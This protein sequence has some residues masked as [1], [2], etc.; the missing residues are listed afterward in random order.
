MDR[1]ELVKSLKKH[2]FN[3]FADEWYYGLVENVFRDMNSVSNDGYV[4]FIK[5]HYT[6]VIKIGRSK[7][8]ISRLNSIKTNNTDKMYLIGYIYTNEY[9]ELEKELHIKFKEK[10]K[11]G[12]WFDISIL[13]IIDLIQKNNGVVVN[14]I[15]DKKLIIENGLVVSNSNIGIDT[16]YENLF[17]IDLFDKIERGV[18]HNI[19]S[20]LQL[21]P[22][23]EQKNYSKKRITMSI[24][25]YAQQRN[26]K[27]FSGNS[28]GMR[29]FM[30][31]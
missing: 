7:D 27:Y 21:M 17:L 12:E 25:K 28:N 20:V 26:I 8:I 9:I 4:Y 29:W 15:F 23:S 31:E 24:K 6:D 13:S 16:I 5:Y 22:K 11:T 18:R 1:D 10:R 19:N 3:M 14:S 2:T 30:L